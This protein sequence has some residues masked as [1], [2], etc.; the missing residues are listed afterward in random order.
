MNEDNNNED[1][2]LPG[3]GSD[4]DV[5]SEQSNISNEPD[6]SIVLPGVSDTNNVDPTTDDSSEINEYAPYV[7]P[8]YVNNQDSLSNSNAEENIAE[9][10]QTTID[11]FVSQSNPQ[12][13]QPTSEVNNTQS[14]QPILN[15]MQESSMDDSNILANDES[16]NVANAPINPILANSNYN[17]QEPTV[18]SEENSYVQ[19]PTIQAENNGYMGPTS[20]TDNTYSQ[21]SVTQQPDTNNYANSYMNDMS[22][23]PYMNSD[24][25]SVQA[26]YMNQ[27]Q[28]VAES[29]Y[30]NFDANNT[31]APYM[32]QDTSNAQAPYM[33]QD[34]SNAQTP[35]MNDAQN[36]YNNAGSAPIQYNQILGGA[37]YGNDN[38]QV[39]DNNQN[40]FQ[41]EQ[42]QF[43]NANYYDQNF[44]FNSTQSFGGTDYN[45]QTQFNGVNYDNQNQQF[46]GANYNNQVQYNGANFEGQNPQISNPN[47]FDPNNGQNVNEPNK[48]KNKNNK[49]F[50]I[51]LVIVLAIAV[52]ALFV[53]LGF[54]LSSKNKK[55]T[56]SSNTTASQQVQPKIEQYYFDNNEYCFDYDSTKWTNDE[57]N[58]SL[59]FDTYSLQYA[60]NYVGSQLGADFKTDN[61]RS[62]LYEMIINQFNAQ[63]SGAN[64]QMETPNDGFISRSDLYYTFFD[65]LDGTTIYRYY[66]V[67]LPDNDIMF[68]FTL[69]NTDTSIDYSTGL[70]VI[71][72]LTSTQKADEENNSNST[73]EISTNEVD[74]NSLNETGATNSVQNKV[75]N[76]LT[77]STNTVANTI[78]NNVANTTSAASNSTSTNTTKNVTNLSDLLNN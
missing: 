45:N 8:D 17:Y 12:D 18:Q 76:A 60:M 10:S 47:Y 55:N 46:N 16:T 53:V 65:V 51:A 63:A 30:T 66:L 4:N 1:F 6:N 33:N 70:E 22:Q 48:Q 25:N 26:P 74:L 31:Q 77:N 32:N 50:T 43:N 14:I 29:S 52:I 56:N 78:G 34:T 36:T 41:P 54:K 64:L 69:S 19:E 39:Q 62:A 67:I 2:V 49:V 11:Q 7:N 71:D 15:D 24:P 75:S 57:E 35:Y 42:N 27:D 72:M 68:Q 9:N 38:A 5:Q 21:E 28:N 40:N 44:Q 13:S 61:G 59:V 73:N 58:K 3:V 37:N 23:T 20:Q